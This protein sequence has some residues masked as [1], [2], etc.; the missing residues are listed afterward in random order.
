MS[1]GREGRDSRRFMFA[2]IYS[3]FQKSIYPEQ[4]SNIVSYEL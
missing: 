3:M 1:S 2:S 4:N